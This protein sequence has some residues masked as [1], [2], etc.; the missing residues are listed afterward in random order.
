MSD[1]HAKPP[2]YELEFQELLIKMFVMDV[3]MFTILIQEIGIG[4]P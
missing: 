4:V 3:G 2:L 1:T